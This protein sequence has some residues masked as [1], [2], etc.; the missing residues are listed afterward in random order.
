MREAVLAGGEDLGRGGGTGEGWGAFAF[1]HDFEEMI[2]VMCACVRSGDLFH[3]LWGNII[4]GRRADRGRG[5]K[6][7]G[8]RSELAG[9]LYGNT[10]AYLGDG[11]A[12]KHGGALL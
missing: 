8:V 4:V 10:T 12:R 2:L 5:R 11:E 6:S 1:W 7:S 9:S 3:Q